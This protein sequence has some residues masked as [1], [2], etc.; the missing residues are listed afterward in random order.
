MARLTAR[1]PPLL[2]LSKVQLDLGGDMPLN[3]PVTQEVVLT[4]TSGSVKWSLRPV[5]SPPARS[6]I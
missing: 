4:C 3:A 5:R 2:S 1:E 6:V